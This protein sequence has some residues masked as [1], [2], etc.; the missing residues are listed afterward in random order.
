[1]TDLLI[2]LASPNP[3][4]TDWVP[5]GNTGSVPTTQPSVRVYRSTAQVVP[6]ATWTAISFDT[7]RYDKGPS[8]HWV[9]GSPTRLTCQVAGTYAV[10][11]HVDVPGGTGGTQR[12]A[13]LRINGGSWIGLGG[14]GGITWNTSSDAQTPAHTVWSFNVGDYVELLVYHDVGVNWNY[15]GSAGA[16]TS[17]DFGMALLGG[18]QGPPGFASPPTY[19]TTLPA[20]PV[21]GQE[22]IL[23]D[24]VTNPN[25]ILRLRY[26]ASNTSSTK[27][28]CVGGSPIFSQQLADESL[29]VADTNWHAFPSPITL[30]VPRGGSYFTEAFA[31][32]YT[33]G[34]SANAVRAGIGIGVN[35][36]LPGNYWADSMGFDARAFGAKKVQA[37]NA[38][39][40]L[41]LYYQW[42][43]VPSSAFA[44]NKY[45]SVMPQKVS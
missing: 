23:V 35:G 26:N 41:L 24:N 42:T 21:D 33:G 16:P 45:L 4:T 17:C 12:L 22:A 40:V 27:W 2:P 18:Q 11:A 38:G 7:V 15:G 29:S 20:S 1:M 6:T 28:E 31:R 5:L 36:A 43:A 19:A 3:A 14:S 37:Y 10:F 30:T 32:F 13:V 9:A 25:Y 8:P 44:A 34:T 39:D